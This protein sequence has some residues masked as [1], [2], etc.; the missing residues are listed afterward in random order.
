VL[1]SVERGMAAQVDR[2]SLVPTRNDWDVA[3][4]QMQLV[5]DE[6]R[7]E[8]HRAQQDRRDAVRKLHDDG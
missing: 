2:V 7:D 4:R 5:V 8:L 1:Q 3:Q 6:L